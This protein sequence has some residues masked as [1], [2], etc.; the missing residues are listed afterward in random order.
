MQPIGT[1]MKNELNGRAN[2]CRLAKKWRTGFTQGP[3]LGGRLGHPL[4]GEILPTGPTG[5]VE[6]SIPLFCVHFLKETSPVL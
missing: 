5:A 2:Q 6:L 1:Q 4:Y 3:P